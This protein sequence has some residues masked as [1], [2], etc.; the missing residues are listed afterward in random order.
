MSWYSPVASENQEM[1]RP[2]GDQAGVRSASPDV[3]VSARQSPFSAGTEK[4]SPRASIATRLPVGESAAAAIRPATSFHCGKSH[5]KSP[6][7][8]IS[9]RLVVLARG[10]YRCRSPACS[11]TTTPAPA[12]ML[13]TS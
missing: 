7:A 1:N 11:K 3:V 8:V 4:M 13:F 9:S 6:L 5:G 12:P 10:S 2:S